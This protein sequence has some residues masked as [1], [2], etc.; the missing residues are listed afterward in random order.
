MFFARL[1]RDILI[2][3]V[4]ILLIRNEADK[5]HLCASFIVLIVICFV[6]KS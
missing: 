6:S 1:R 5:V 3:S 2:V 4:C